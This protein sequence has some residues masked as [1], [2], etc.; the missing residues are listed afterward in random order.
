MERIKKFSKLT[1]IIAVMLF[2]LPIFAQQTLLDAK[3]R[4][5]LNGVLVMTASGRQHLL[6]GDMFIKHE[7]IVYQAAKKIGTVNKVLWAGEI[8]VI[9]G[10][11]TRVNET[12]GMVKE[13]P[14]LCEGLYQETATIKNLGIKN[15]RK[16]LDGVGIKIK[17]R[18]FS[19]LSGQ[20]YILYDENNKHL[21]KELEYFAYYKHKLGSDIGDI[22]N[23][24][25]MDEKDVASAALRIIDGYGTLTLIVPELN[26]QTWRDIKPFFEQ[27]ASGQPLDEAKFAGLLEDFINTR[28]KFVFDADKKIV[29]LTP[30]RL[31]VIMQKIR[32]DKGS[33]SENISTSRPEIPPADKTDI[34]LITFAQDL[35]DVAQEAKTLLDAKGR[36]FLNSVLVVDASG[37]EHLLV[38]EAITSH[39]KIIERASKQIGVVKKVLWA[40]EIEVI[41]GAVTRVNETA[42]IITRK[43]EL[44]EDLNQKTATIKNLGIKNLKKF[45]NGT[46]AAI[47]K[48]YF[49][50]LQES[51]YIFYD[52][53]NEHLHE[54]LAYLF[55]YRHDLGSNDLGT[56]LN[57]MTIAY[58]A[59]DPNLWVL[60]KEDMMKC[61]RR[62]IT[63]YEKLILIIP[64][65]NTK[66]WQDIKPFFRW[67]AVWD[68]GVVETVGPMRTSFA[69]MFPSL[70]KA[71]SDTRKE[72][73]NNAAKTLL[74]LTPPN[75]SLVPVLETK[76]ETKKDLSVPD[77]KGK[78]Q[79]VKNILK[80]MF[81]VN[82][83][84]DQNVE[85]KGQKAVRISK[86]K[87][88]MES[89][90]A[91]IK[92]GDYEGAIYDYNDMLKLADNND[93]YMIAWMHYSRGLAL[94]RLGTTLYSFEAAEKDLLFAYNKLSLIYD[95]KNT[96][97]KNLLARDS[98]FLGVV[99][100]KLAAEADKTAL[101]GSAKN[102]YRLANKYQKKA[103]ELS[104]NGQQW[105]DEEL[106]T[107]YKRF[108]K[109]AISKLN[110]ATINDLLYTG[111]L[112]ALLNSEYSK[113]VVDLIPSLMTVLNMEKSND[114]VRYGDV[115][116]RMEKLQEIALDNKKSTSFEFVDISSWG[117]NNETDAVMGELERAKLGGDN[118]Q[119]FIKF[120]F[121]DGEFYRKVFKA[122]LEDLQD[123][124]RM[125]EKANKIDKLAA[126]SIVLMYFVTENPGLIK[127]ILPKDKDAK[128]LL[129]AITYETARLGGRVSVEADKLEIE[130]RGLFGLDRTIAEKNYRDIKRAVER[131]KSY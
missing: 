111:G 117:K 118:I 22:K 71:F 86:I 66:T 109:V 9:D 72:M 14:E 63:N 73:L 21:E 36:S 89:A 80:N 82:K 124:S 113:E 10:K 108:Q 92:T 39:E 112:R 107:L 33:Q 90:A 68:E 37:K 94:Y 115:R 27:T 88:F 19:N 16:F 87:E 13:K 42:G 83:S 18:Y 46:G 17:K 105:G 65:L 131:G 129:S 57:W 45:L 99:Y 49:S 120:L 70:H 119:D 79:I 128:E 75:Q 114:D 96:E 91:K 25:Y 26:T 2:S 6:V 122:M 4:S 31:S 3:G 126:F 5:F 50:K 24:A 78:M 69:D 81:G 95:W 85:T 23:K 130:S 121:S 28:D 67:M 56:D 123:V 61:A 52:Q 74:V 102:D 93:A 48:Q 127:D 62:V 110:D 64:E 100:A 35:P 77:A 44:C 106:E 103:K 12:A 54:S 101:P 11:V 15:L 58:D 98:Y 38:G 47:K 53:S 1:T 51:D 41:E 43:P 76:E 32:K 104:Y 34:S 40:G 20:D 60:E 59:T 29:I 84:A 7:E 8:E 55:Y 125:Q 30:S 97:I 116:Y